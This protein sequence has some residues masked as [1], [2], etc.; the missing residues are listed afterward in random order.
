[1]IIISQYFL[2]Y[3]FDNLRFFRFSGVY[4][5]SDLFA[6]YNKRS[7]NFASYSKRSDGGGKK[8]VAV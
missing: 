6:G 1:M 5:R 7:D 8:S 3:A 4:A 2:D